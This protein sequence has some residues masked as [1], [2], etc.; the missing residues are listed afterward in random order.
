MGK[1]H[2]VVVL[3]AAFILLEAAA[4]EDERRQVM[5]PVDGGDDRTC[6]IVSSIICQS[7][8]W[9]NASFP[10]PRDQNQA[11]AVSE[12]T[13]FLLL[14][15]SG[16]SGAVVHF[17]CSYYFPFCTYTSVSEF[18][19][20][21][22]CK[23]FCEFV[24][25]RCE[26]FFEGTGFEW[27]EFLNCSGSAFPDGNLA[28]LECFAPPNPQ[29][30]TIPTIPGLL[31]P[32]SVTPT[33][34]ST[35]TGMT[36]SS[37]AIRM[38]TTTDNIIYATKSASRTPIIT[39]TPSP[40]NARQCLSI[41]TKYC[42]REIGYIDSTFP[43]RDGETSEDAENSIET[44]LAFIESK[45]SQAIVHFLCAYYI[46]QCVDEHPFILEPCREL[47]EY[48][49]DDCNLN[50]NWPE[51]FNCDQFP[52]REEGATCTSPDINEL[53]KVKI[54]VIDGVT[55]PEES[56][57]GGAVA[58]HRHLHD[59]VPLILIPAIVLLVSVL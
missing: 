55:S 21:Y 29:D 39:P 45:C 37:R 8:D 56:P 18:M 35:V 40:V 47:C 36:S 32:P 53:S 31:T 17:Y 20:L 12:I 24:R 3:V 15:G 30:L 34:T 19:Y 44:H 49:R 43:N 5:P 22:P 26:P 10:N 9:L 2:C 50:L 41:E 33:E 13:D 4:Q 14:F 27:P 58:S 11:V 51:K 16:C 38:T 1:Y 25:E 46:P 59:I 7:V 54:P 42:P 52:Y 28:N 57:R 23:S 48:V 6:E